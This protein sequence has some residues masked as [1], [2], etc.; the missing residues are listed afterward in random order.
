MMSRPR[1]VVV[2]IAA[3]RTALLIDLENLLHSGPDY[4]SPAT[5][6]RRLRR[7]LGPAQKATFRL[8]VASA[9]VLERYVLDST[10]LVNLPMRAVG[11]EPD[12][13]DRYLLDTA[14][15]LATIG[16]G[17]FIIASGDHAFADFARSHA[18]TVVAP[19][20][21][22]LSKSLAEAAQQTRIAA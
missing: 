1:P 11:N 18:V 13:A 7:L 4:V 10:E 2:P 21:R 19:D 16:F 3:T 5:A 8:A 20:S 17:H 22:C 6:D 15:H 14:R 9:S 12:A